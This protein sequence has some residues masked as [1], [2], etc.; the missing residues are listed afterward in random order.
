MSYG[1][2]ITIEL[3]VSLDVIRKEIWFTKNPLVW[4]IFEI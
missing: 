2:S 4:K 1:K 3:F